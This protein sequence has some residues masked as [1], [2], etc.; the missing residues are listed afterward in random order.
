MA[1]SNPSFEIPEIK[2]SNIPELSAI[3]LTCQHSRVGK[4]LPNVLYVHFSALSALEPLLQSYESAARLAAPQLKEPTLVKFS[5]DKAKISYLFYPD[6]DTDPHPALQASI[7]VDLQSLQVSYR[8]Y[9]T[10]ENPP[11]LHRKETFVTSTL[12]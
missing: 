10:S 6:F 1:S 7:Q 11:V 2:L 9:S 12:R 4:L 3:A 5:T 8:D